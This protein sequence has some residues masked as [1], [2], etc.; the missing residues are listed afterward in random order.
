MV[1]LGKIAYEAYSAKSKGKSLATGDDLPKWE[2][3]PWE[4]R[5]AWNASAA[6]VERAVTA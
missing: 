2:D 4:I 3:L 1:N 6:A 5:D